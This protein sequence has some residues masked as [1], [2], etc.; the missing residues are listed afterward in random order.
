MRCRLNLSSGGKILEGF[1][2]SP[3]KRL[4]ELGS[5]KN[6]TP[7][8]F[9]LLRGAALGPTGH[10]AAREQHRG[11]KYFKGSAFLK[12]LSKTG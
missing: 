3:I 9:L 1:G 11:Q 10:R 4:R 2:C 5:S 12:S 6:V 8:V 7:L